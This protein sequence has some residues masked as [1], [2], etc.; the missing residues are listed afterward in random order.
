MCL[1]KI[2]KGKPEWREGY[3]VFRRNRDGTLS[4]ELCNSSFE[5]PLNTWIKDKETYP[6][7][8]T[9]GREEYKTGFHVFK[10][11][12][13]ARN[14]DSPNLPSVV[15]KVRTGNPVTHGRQEK[16]K[17]GVFKEMYIMED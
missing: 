17:V 15:R 16:Y 14:W 13:G 8:V 6:L 12:K 11:K 3:K 7:A 5:R 1:S 2:Q 4:S 10:T 9:E